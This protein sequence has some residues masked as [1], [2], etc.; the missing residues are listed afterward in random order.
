[1]VKPSSKVIASKGKS[2]TR[3]TPAPSRGGG[4]ESISVRPIDNGYIICKSTDHGYSEVY[5][6]KKPKLEVPKA[7]K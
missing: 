7:T 6:A 1:M 5:S 3:A 2:P 4:Y